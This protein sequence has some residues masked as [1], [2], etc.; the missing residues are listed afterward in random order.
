MQ[1]NRT[2]RIAVVLAT[3]SV[4]VVLLLGVVAGC[5]GEKAVAPATTAPESANL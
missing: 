2:R 1:S 5:G 4:L 3:L